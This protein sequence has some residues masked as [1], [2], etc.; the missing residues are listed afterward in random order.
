[1][2][3]NT[4]NK[5]K[6]FNLEVYSMSPRY[7]VILEK[8][9]DGIYIATVPALKGCHSHGATKKEAM[10]NIKEA[11]ELY[12]ECLVE[13]NVVFPEDIETDTLEVRIDTA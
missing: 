11:I 2:A 1:M 12:L 8:D 4:Y 3:I 6:P 10:E 7:T 9:E 13:D 5:G